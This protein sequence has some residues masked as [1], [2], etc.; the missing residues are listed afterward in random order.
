MYLKRMKEKNDDFSNVSV[1]KVKR[2]FAKAK[3][4]FDAHVEELKTQ[5]MCKNKEEGTKRDCP[6]GC[7]LRPFKTTHASFKCDSCH[8]YVPEGADMRGCRHCDWD[9]GMKC[10]PPIVTLAHLQKRLHDIENDIEKAGM[11][12]TQLALAEASL[13]KLDTDVD[14]ATAREMALCSPVEVAE[15][16]IRAGRRELIRRVDKILTQVDE[17]FVKIRAEEEASKC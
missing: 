15:D 2:V 17:T 7:G 9:V 11:N 10:A 3:A 8:C 1:M 6:K 13:H 14:A 12:R 16:E 5:R 4:D